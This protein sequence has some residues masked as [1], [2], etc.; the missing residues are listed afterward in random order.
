MDGPVR[1]L[2][3]GVEEVD[4]CAA[5]LGEIGRAPEVIYGPLPRRICAEPCAG[6]AGPSGLQFGP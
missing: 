1:R 6:H 4:H 5:T 2:P 3:A